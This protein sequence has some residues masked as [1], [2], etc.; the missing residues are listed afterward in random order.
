MKL[1]KNINPNIIAVLGAWN[2][3][4][5]KHKALF[6]ELLAYSKKKGL[7]PYVIIVYPNPGKF[8]YTNYFRD[9]FDLNARIEFLKYLGINNVLALDIAREDLQ[10]G[11]GA[12]FDQLFI[13]TGIKLT[14]LWVGENQSFSTGDKGSVFSIKDECS[15]RDIKLRVLKN[16]HLVVLE[17]DAVYRDFRQG[18]L[19]LAA[20]VIGQFPTYRLN[21]DAQIQMYDGTYNALLRV[22]PFDKTNEIATSVV[23]TNEKLAPMDRPD[24]YDW[25][26]LTEKTSVEEVENY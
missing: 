10:A 15:R 6:K 5:P 17:K 16:S 22:Q 3:V 1:H 26:V 4:L 20:A 18:R 9:Y 24:G 12:L 2:P 11:A 25:L 21:G 13:D 14:E 8:I 23:I 19:A 7:N